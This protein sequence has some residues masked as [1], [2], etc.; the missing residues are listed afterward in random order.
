M[1]ITKI[2]CREKGLSIDEIK[3]GVA[4]AVYLDNIRK[5]LH[6]LHEDQIYED[7]ISLE[8]RHA[9]PAF[10]LRTALRN[11]YKSGPQNIHSP[12]FIV[13]GTLYASG[14]YIKVTDNGVRGSFIKSPY[15]EL[16]LHIKKYQSSL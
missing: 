8:P 2:E 6:I 3:L 10:D 14:T 15:S 12:T 11:L 16:F 1:A 9:Q 5:L 13:P 4:R 7:P